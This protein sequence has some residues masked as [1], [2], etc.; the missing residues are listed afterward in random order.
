[1]EPSEAVVRSYF[2]RMGAGDARGAFALFSA[3]FSYRVMGTTP[4]SHECHDMPDFVARVLRPFTAGLQDGRIELV[5]DEYIASGDR[6]AVL[7]HSRAMG[8]GGLPYDNEYVFVFRVRGDQ[9][10]E[11]REYLDTALV[12]TAVFGKSLVG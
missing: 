4:I 1:M 10:T 12:E 2:E 7:A 3:P 9:I 6:V 11:V 8:T 5:A